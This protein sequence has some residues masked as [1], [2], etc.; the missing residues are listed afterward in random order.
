M[1]RN[2]IKKVAIYARVS[3]MRQAEKDLPIESQLKRLRKYVRG[4]GW[5]IVKE[6]VDRGISALDDK[7]PI[8]KT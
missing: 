4:R 1:N 7:S 8:F 5:N 3:S 6:Y 2:E